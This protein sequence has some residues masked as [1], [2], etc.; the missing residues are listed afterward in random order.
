MLKCEMIHQ[1]SVR[2]SGSPEFSGEF[3]IVVAGLGTAGA[4]AAVAAAETGAR[5]CAVER[6]GYA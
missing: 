1:K 4:V 2:S 5:V 6:M 3:D